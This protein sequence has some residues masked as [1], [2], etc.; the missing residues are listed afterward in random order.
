[1]NAREDQP[2]P[3]STPGGVCRF[4]IDTPP[5][6]CEFHVPGG[7]WFVLVEGSGG[8]G[9][10]AGGN[11]TNSTLGLA[12]GG[13]GG[14]APVFAIPWRVEPGTTVKVV[15]GNGGLP[16]KG[17]A[18]R[19]PGDARS[20]GGDG[21]D[22]HPSYFGDLKFPGAGGG[23]ASGAGGEKVQRL[24]YLGSRGGDGGKGDQQPP[25]GN[26]KRGES[27]PLG[28]D[29]GD[30]G[31]ALEEREGG[32]GGG[33]GGAAA[34]GGKG[35]NAFRGD[36]VTQGEGSRPEK[37]SGAG[38]GGGAGGD[39]SGGGDGGQGGSGYVQVTWNAA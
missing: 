26:G 32:G 18:E 20:R 9:G 6:D 38:G 14:G 30:G 33:G 2:A 16:G 10:G 29:G 17:G 19:P 25:A 15:V 7:V 8:G 35:G 13:G 4:T 23:R 31:L 27:A 12:G 36:A 34:K 28:N 3:Q 22:G 39:N 1:M 5:G 21:E 24:P 11:G 37:D